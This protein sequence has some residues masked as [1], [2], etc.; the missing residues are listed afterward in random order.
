MEGSTYQLL[1]KTKRLR[2]SGE[3]PP[4]LGK[5]LFKWDAA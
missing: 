1:V 5:T 3:P 4:W 2:R